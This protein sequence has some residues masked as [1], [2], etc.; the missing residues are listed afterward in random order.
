MTVRYCKTCDSKLWD[1]N[2]SGYCRI[3]RSVARRCTH[4]DKRI[5]QRSPT[6]LCL[7]HYQEAL[8]RRRTQST[9]AVC[10]RDITQKSRS[11]L[12]KQ[13]WVSHMREQAVARRV[14]AEELLKDGVAIEEVSAQVGLSIKTLKDELGVPGE[15]PAIVRDPEYPFRA[16]RVAAMAIGSRP[17]EIVGRGQA[18]PLVRA[19]WAVMA[20]MHSRGM[21]LSQIGRRVRRDHSTVSHGLEQI[22]SFVA[23]DA[24]FAALV[25]RVDQA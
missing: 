18:Q 4:C 20:G 12:C 23:R 19:R 25:K 14:K 9:C 1:R 3:H 13:H 8:E 5:W 2:L 22:P 21:G 6:G 15:L 24:A 17:E 10:D 7:K 16:L 11:G